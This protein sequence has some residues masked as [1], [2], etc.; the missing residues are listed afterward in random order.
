MRS[1]V[2]RSIEKS[3]VHSPTLS[4]LTAKPTVNS[5]Q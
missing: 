5:N 1:S 2:L 4:N 3:V